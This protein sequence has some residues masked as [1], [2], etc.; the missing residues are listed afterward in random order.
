MPIET[1]CQGCSKR[2][3]V[4]DE[5]AGKLAKCPHCQAIY[6]VPQSP[7]VASWGAGSTSDSNLA[8]SD[9]WHLKMPDGLSFGPVSRA[10]LDRWLADGRI[11]AA[12]QIM[13][14]ADGRWVGANQIYP[15]LAM[16]SPTSAPQFP[17]S[18]SP[19]S[20][21][22][23]PAGTFAKPVDAQAGGI[24]PYASPSI[25]GYYTPAPARYREQHRGGTIL[26]LS[27]IGPF[28]CIF[29]SIAAVVMGITDLNE[30]KRGVRDPSGRGLTIAGLVI[31]S[32]YLGLIVLS[33]GIGIIGAILD[34]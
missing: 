27:I 2:L 28:F 29:L 21:S 19:A 15:Q 9:R 3:R 26:A 31:G 34:S 32:L 17:A 13:H 12:S 30:M 4:A 8:A 1:I 5:H 20:Q 11:T 22:P 23:F 16:W 6:T 18:Q 24:N 33:L 25:A 10:E 7:W 14:E